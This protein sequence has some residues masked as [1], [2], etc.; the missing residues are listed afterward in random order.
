MHPLEQACKFLHPYA[1]ISILKQGRLAK[2]A[3]QGQQQCPTHILWRQAASIC[4]Q[5]CFKIE[6]SKRSI[7]WGIFEGWIQVAYVCPCIVL[8]HC[9]VTEPQ[10][11]DCD[12]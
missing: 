5:T 7:Y 12:F 8:S 1:D 3:R 6:L 9:G 4:I 10:L 11:Q 2:T